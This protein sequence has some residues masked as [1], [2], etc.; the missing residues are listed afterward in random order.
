MVC[1]WMSLLQS[2]RVGSHSAVQYFFS[3]LVAHP[4]LLLKLGDITI[5]LRM[6]APRPHL[7]GAETQLPGGMGV[8]ASQ[9]PRPHPS[10]LPT[11]HLLQQHLSWKQWARSLHGAW[12]QA[13]VQEAA[14]SPSLC[15]SEAGRGSS[16]PREGLVQ[17]SP[18]PSPVAVV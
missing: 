16:V 13:G 14:S 17:L 15:S 5:K 6:L 8:G 10:P 18:S 12:H 1:A 9:C 11:P 4:R 7:A 3:D 2:E